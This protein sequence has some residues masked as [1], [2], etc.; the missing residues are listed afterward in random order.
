MD[1]S[2]C[3]YIRLWTHQ[4]LHTSG[5][6]HIRLRTHQAAD[7]SG[8]GY[9]GQS[10]QNSSQNHSILSSTKYQ[11]L[12]LYIAESRAT[13]LAVVRLLISRTEQAIVAPALCVPSTMGTS[14][15]TIV[16]PAL[17]VPS[18]VGTCRTT[19]VETPPSA[20][21]VCQFKF[22]YKFKLKKCVQVQIIS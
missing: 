14:R 16:A 22:V 5:C 7:T 21:S 6:G 15:T 20:R 18:V 11:D 19:I 4:A 17:C 9:I 10:P 8:F 1:T 12:G 13:R 2:G 3:E